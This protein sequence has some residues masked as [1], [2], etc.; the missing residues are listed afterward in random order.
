M[1]LDI[2]YVKTMFLLQFG[3]QNTK[4]LNESLKEENAMMD[5]VTMCFN[6]QKKIFL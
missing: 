1:W 6:F 3:K 2:D 5:R 4:N